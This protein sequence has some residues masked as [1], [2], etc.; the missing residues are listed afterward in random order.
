[1]VCIVVNQARYSLYKRSIE[2]T[3]TVPLI[4]LKKFLRKI[5][6]QKPYN[7]IYETMKPERSYS[8]ANHER[9]GAR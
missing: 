8:R 5:G 6:K 2:I 9:A 4:N 7:W 1:M 3:M